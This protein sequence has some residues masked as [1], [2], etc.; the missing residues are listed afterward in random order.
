MSEKYHLE[1]LL[2]LFSHR[3]ISYFL[4]SCVCVYGWF[5]KD[6]SVLRYFA[7]ILIFVY[8]LI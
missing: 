6:L 2:R 5:V 8:L 7:N 4:A 3:F 1:S